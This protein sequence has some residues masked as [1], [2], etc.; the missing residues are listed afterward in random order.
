MTDK[1]GAIW[2]PNKRAIRTAIQ[3]TVGVFLAIVSALAV[4]VLVAPQVLEAIKDVLPPSWYAWL[5]GFVAVVGAISAAL[6]RV[7]AIPQVDEFLKR[8]G[9]GSTPAHVS[10]PSGVQEEVDRA[11]VR[12]ATDP[13]DVQV[14][15]VLEAANRLG[16]STSEV[17]R[18][19]YRAA[20]GEE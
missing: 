7:M 5:V 6:A 14:N 2:F 18:D 17:T 20:L 15:T 9:A 19:S 3:V 12:T 8:F 4:F 1:S 16:I 11:V 13:I 10:L